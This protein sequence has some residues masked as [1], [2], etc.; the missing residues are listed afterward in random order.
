MFPGKIS[1]NTTS[2]FV[3]QILFSLTI[4]KSATS[5]LLPNSTNTID[6]IATNS[7][8][9]LVDG[10][11]S[12]FD[13]GYT[14]DTPV[15]PV[16]PCL[17][18][19]VAAMSEL[20]VRDFTENLTPKTYGLT[21]YPSV[22]IVTDATSSSE[23][24][25]TRF[26]I[27]GIW[28]GVRHMIL[29]GKFQNVLFTL[30]WEGAVV[31]YV[32]VVR[33]GPALGVVRNNNSQILSER[34]DALSISNT[35]ANLPQINNSVVITDP[36]DE[37]KLDVSFTLT[38]QAFTI[39]EVFSTVLAALGN[40]AEAPKDQRLR[41]ISLSP[42][43]YDTTLA[44]FDPRESPQTGP[45]I[46]SCGETLMAVAM[47]PRYMVQRSEFREVVLTIRVDGVLIGEGFMNRGRLRNGTSPSFG[48]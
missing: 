44:I 2:S 41:Y 38:G 48:A 33:S 13:I 11:D 12:R 15:L 47:I 17:M 32:M 23:T 39:Y 25:E 6:Y 24:I 36:V 14:F 3:L 19:A 34:S 27:W 26:I 22:S 21:D 43:Y 30:K 5:T 29:S 35:T 28:K 10:V 18:N 46:L 37:A 8:T 7:N 31:G 9:T 45:P 16:T 20:A 40:L 4:S 1:F 42:E